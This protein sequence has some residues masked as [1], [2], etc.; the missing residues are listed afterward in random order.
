MS[1]ANTELW[2]TVPKPGGKGLQTVCLCHCLTKKDVQVFFYLKILQYYSSPIY[3][4]SL[5]SFL[6]L[7]QLQATELWL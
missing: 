5:T 2:W 4:K 6:S 1:E 7:T 3:P